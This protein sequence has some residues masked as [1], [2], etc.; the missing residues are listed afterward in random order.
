MLSLS[1][2]MLELKAAMTLLCVHTSHLFPLRD[3][4]I[5]AAL[6][7]FPL[8]SASSSLGEGYVRSAGLSIMSICGVNQRSRGR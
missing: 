6:H 3:R 4:H 5:V 7:V 8:L 2:Y 1:S